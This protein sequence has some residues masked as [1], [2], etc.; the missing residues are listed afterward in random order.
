MQMR[1]TKDVQPNWRKNTKKEKKK[2]G[3]PKQ[4][5]TEAH[6]GAQQMIESP[7][8]RSQTTRFKKQIRWKSIAESSPKQ[9]DSDNST[10]IQTQTIYHCPYS[11]HS[12]YNPPQKGLVG[13]ESKKYI[14]K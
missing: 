7:K 5:C 12:K 1:W 8:I 9:P 3:A 6:D 4:S 11:S 14:A 13:Q 2:Q 10:N